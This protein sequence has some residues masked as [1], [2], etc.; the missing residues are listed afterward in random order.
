MGL[1]GTALNFKIVSKGP[2]YRLPSYIKLDKCREEVA[3][4][5]NDLRNRWCK[6]DGVEDCALNWKELSSQLWILV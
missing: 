2:K 1:D 4:A 6:R 5:L 3:S